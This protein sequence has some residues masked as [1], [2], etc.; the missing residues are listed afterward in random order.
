[1]HYY[2]Y[3]IIIGMAELVDADWLKVQFLLGSTIFINCTV[4]Q[5]MTFQTLLGPL[6]PNCT[7]HPI[8]TYTSNIQGNVSVELIN[9]S[10]INS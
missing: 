5:L 2:Y 4:V 6:I 8:I 1:M 3:F 7:D 9:S 10:G